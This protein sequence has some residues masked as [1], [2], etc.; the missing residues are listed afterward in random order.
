[1]AASETDFSALVESGDAFLADEWPLIVRAVQALTPFFVQ[2]FASGTE[3]AHVLEGLALGESTTHFQ[4]RVMVVGTDLLV[5]ENTGTEGTPIWTTRNTFATGSGLV[6]ATDHGGLGGLADDDHTQYVLATGARNITGS[7]SLVNAADATLAITI[8]SGTTVE[9]ISELAL[10]DQ[11]TTRW[12]I[13]K[14]ANGKFIIRDVVNGQDTMTVDANA[15]ADKLVITSNGVGIGGAPAAGKELDVAGDI[16]AD[17]DVAAATG[18][19]TGALTS[20]S[21]D[22]TASN[23]LTKAWG[24]TEST[25]SSSAGAITFDFSASNYFEVTLTENLTSITL[26][27]VGIPGPRTIVLKQAAAASYTVA[28]WPAGVKWANDTAPSMPSG[29]DDEKVITI[30]VKA[31]GTSFRGMFAD[32]F[33]V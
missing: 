8:D 15:G 20:G 4:W 12:S 32:D 14:A 17:G 23:E 10:A 9:Q 11:T 29:F 16:T 31:D 25:P 21:F 22:T 33:T 19:I 5:Q 28:G 3:P 30:L 24:V 18:A 6:T 1:M 26:S 2:Q 27:N 7:Q 13:R